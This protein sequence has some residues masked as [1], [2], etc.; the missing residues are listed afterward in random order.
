MRPWTIFV[1][2]LFRHLNRRFGNKIADGYLI[3]WSVKRLIGANLI[4]CHLYYCC[5]LPAKF[6]KCDK[7]RLRSMPVSSCI[8]TIH[9][10]SLNFTI[11]FSYDA[12]TFYLL[13]IYY[14]I[15]LLLW[16]SLHNTAPIGAVW[17][18][19]TLFAINIS[20]DEKSRRLL[21]WLAH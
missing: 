12:F 18:G 10:F 3:K 13:F 5:V 19:S 21:L 2:W 6:P 14:F 8:L 16:F 11:L 15:I 4:R 7:Y 17:S 20:A 1:C 9:L